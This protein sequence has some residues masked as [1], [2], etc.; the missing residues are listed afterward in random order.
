LTKAFPELRTAV[1]DPVDKTWTRLGEAIASLND[2]RTI[3]RE[4]IADWLCEY[5]GCTHPF[6]SSG[7]KIVRSVKRKEREEE[8]FKD[9]LDNAICGEAA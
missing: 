3:A 4:R 7:V 8:V 1:V 5:G 2:R 6:E 9:R